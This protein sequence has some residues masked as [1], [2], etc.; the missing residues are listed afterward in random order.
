MKFS[1]RLTRAG[2][3]FI[4]LGS[5][6]AVLP[7]QMD[8]ATADD[9]TCTNGNHYRLTDSASGTTDHVPATVNSGDRRVFMFI[10]V[11]M[12]LTEATHHLLH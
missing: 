7:Q 11:Q 9:K 3:T 2:L 10:E 5:V 6:A 1:Q 8:R 4:L 12:V